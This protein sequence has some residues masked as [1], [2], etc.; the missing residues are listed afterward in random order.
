[1]VNL[2]IVQEDNTTAEVDAIVNAAPNPGC[3]GRRGGWG[4]SPGCGTGTADNVPKAS[5]GKR[6][7]VSCR[8]SPDHRG[9]KFESKICHHTVGPM[10]G[11][12]EGTVM[13]GIHPELPQAFLNKPYSMAALKDVLLEAIRL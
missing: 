7:P 13:A 5:G 2:K 9:W 10:Y 3:W 1:M 8:R 4:Y 11:V 6:D 12:D